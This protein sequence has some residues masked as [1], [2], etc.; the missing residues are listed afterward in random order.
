MFSASH[1]GEIMYAK[2]SSKTFWFNH[3]FGIQYTSSG[4]AQII[5]LK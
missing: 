5:S 3:V 1:K 4:S 2:H